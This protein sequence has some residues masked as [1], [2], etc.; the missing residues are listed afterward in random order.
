MFIGPTA[1]LWDRYYRNDIATGT[2][3]KRHDTIYGPGFLIWIPNAI[4]FQTGL[5]IEYQYLR[6]KSNDPTHSFQDHLVMT[7]VVSQF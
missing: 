2:T 3:S 1:V 7:S 6:D 4:A 5:K